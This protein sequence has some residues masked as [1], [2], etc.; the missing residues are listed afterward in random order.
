MPCSSSPML[1]R[2]QSYAIRYASVV[3]SLSSQVQLRPG[4]CV[5][6]DNRRTLHAR[7]AF[8]LAPGATATDQPIRWLKVHL[9]PIALTF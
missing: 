6:F 5:A 2:I 3:S 1:Q 8:E 7:T 9:R 4:E